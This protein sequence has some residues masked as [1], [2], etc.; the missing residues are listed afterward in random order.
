MTARTRRTRRIASFLSLALGAVTLSVAS[1]QGEAVRAS[2]TV[3]GTPWP[4][5]D[6]LG[7]KL[8]QQE[9]A[10]PPK[11]GRFVGIFYF[12]WLGEHG[13]ATDG[14]YD[15]SKILKRHPD[16][17]ST[18]TS[19]PW[20][21]VG[22]YHFWGE[23]LFGYYRSSD[24]WVIRRHA[25]L[26]ADAGIDTLI[27]DATN[28][29]TYRHRYMKIL[30]VFTQI[31]REGDKTPQVAFMVNT[32]AD[33]TAQE[34]YRDLYEPGHYTALW[35][36]WQGKP[37]LLCD[38]AEASPEIR[39]FFTLRRAHW[40]FAQVNTP[41]A[42]HWEA[43]YPQVYG[44]TDDPKVPE[45]INVSVAQNLRRSDGKVT[46]MSNGNARG[47]SFHNGAMDTR[48]GAVNHGYNFQEQWERALALQPPFVMVTGWNEWI[49]GRWRRPGSS[50]V[51]VDQFDQEYSRDIEMAKG[52]HRDNYYYQL[53]ASVR[54]YKGAPPLPQASAPKT[55]HLD[56]GFDQWRDVLPAYR[57]HVGETQPRDHAGC[58][59]LRYTNRTG[60]NDLVLMKIA[61]DK[62][63]IYFYARTL[64]AITPAERPA[65]LAVFIDRDMNPDTGWEGYDLVVN[66]T[67]VDAKKTW[68][69]RSCAPGAW[70][71]VVP[72]PYRVSGREI[73]IEVPR[74]RC[75]LRPA[76]TGTS[77]DFKWVDNIQRPGDIMDF[78]VT[79]DVAPE[80]RFSYRYTAP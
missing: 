35:F 19:P 54:R 13:T 65:R 11:S 70:E 53:V 6:E 3:P 1:E 27:F 28:R 20:G 36:H 7:R 69:E 58:G 30:K 47:R 41:F 75:E 74:D 4:A 31:R 37:L 5:V 77:F 63:S 10:G 45:Q 9:E 25:Y 48:P 39:A 64:A 40:P 52:A 76:T 29:V 14:P 57:D 66:R 50:L 71:K 44:Y 56:K 60:R 72:A 42:W 12:L 67:L 8:P 51:F 59:G 2:A 73:Q 55:I 34:L 38:P 22:R 24:P 61:R 16:A 17:L 26:L 46:N 78:Y 79:G 43:A 18:P 23:P 15:V 49:A 33:E 32:R 62:R 80:G 68:I 21:P